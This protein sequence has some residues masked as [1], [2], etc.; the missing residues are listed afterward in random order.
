MEHSE[1]K[2]NKLIYELY[3]LTPDEIAIIEGG[4]NE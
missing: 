2:I 1:D 3:E 4:D